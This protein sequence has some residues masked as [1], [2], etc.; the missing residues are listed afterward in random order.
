M[1]KHVQHLDFIAATAYEIMQKYNHSS[2]DLVSHA[3]VELL[4]RSWAATKGL[5]KLVGDLDEEPELEFASGL[6]IRTMIV[7]FFISL[8]GGDILERG[9]DGT[10]DEATRRSQVEQYFLS[11]LGDGLKQAANHF[12]R[13]ESNG[14]ISELKLHEVL[15]NLTK[16]YSHF[17]KPY[18]NDKKV[19]TNYPRPLKNDQLFEKISENDDLK[20]FARHFDTYHMYSKYEHFSI[21]SYDTFRR[22]QEDQIDTIKTMIEILTYHIHQIVRMLRYYSTEDEFLK[23]QQTALDTYIFK[24]V[25]GMSDEEIYNHFN[26]K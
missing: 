5:A 13:M 1:K 19:E 7:D 8:R 12:A 11:V 22:K 14:H 26:A 20:N 9:L 16:R 15:D 2:L 25:F 18:S 10:E 21:M 6:V 3:Y 17:L 23:E 24:E 4:S